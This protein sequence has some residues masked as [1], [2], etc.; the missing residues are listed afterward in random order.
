MSEPVRETSNRR[1]AKISDLPGWPCPPRVRDIPTT[2][3]SWGWVDVH[4][5]ESL[6]AVVV[7]ELGYLWVNGNIVPKYRLP[8]DQHASPGAVVFWSDGG[9]GLYLH[10]KSYSSL[11]S[12]S[13]LDH[14]PDKWLPVTEVVPR[15]PQWITR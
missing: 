7:D 4:D 8:D 15:L 12:I 11:P 2:P 9:I 13:R 3:D 14:E 6:M 10:P 1:H 5:V